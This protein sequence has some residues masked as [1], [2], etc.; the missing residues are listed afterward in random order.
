MRIV[1]YTE[2]RKN[3]KAVLDQVVDDADYTIIARRDGEDVVVM[4]LDHYNSLMETLYL[5]RS[6]ANAEHLSKSIEQ[7]RKARASEA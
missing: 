3:L 1:T 7:Y 6:P 5:L 2:A 4:S